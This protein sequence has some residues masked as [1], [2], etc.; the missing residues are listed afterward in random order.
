MNDDLIST[1]ASTS[2][3]AAPPNSI[4]AL[5]RLLLAT[6]AIAGIAGG[7]FQAYRMYF[8]VR[9]TVSAPHSTVTRAH[10]HHR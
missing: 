7:L 9:Q 1:V 8:I 6:L 5:L 3:S 2:P 4:R 10:P